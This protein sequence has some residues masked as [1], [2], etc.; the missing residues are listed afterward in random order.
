MLEVRRRWWNC[1]SDQFS[2]VAISVT[3]RAIVVKKKMHSPTSCVW[4][5]PVFCR[6]TVKSK[7]FFFK[8]W[9]ERWGINYSNDHLDGETPRNPHGYIYLLS[10]AAESWWGGICDVITSHVVWTR[11]L[12]CLFSLETKDEN[13]CFISFLFLTSCG[14]QFTPIMVI[15]EMSPQLSGS[16]DTHW[17]WPHVCTWTTQK[18]DSVV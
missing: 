11:G 3:G 15:N 5:T 2:F 7:G 18:Q 8:L 4:M 12:K 6:S 14:Y 9:M 17:T 16:S 13:S 1:T 10:L